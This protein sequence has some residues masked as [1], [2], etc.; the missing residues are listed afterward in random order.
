MNGNNKIAYVLIFALFFRLFMVFGLPLKTFDNTIK[1]YHYAAINL[2]EGRGYSHSDKPPYE[3][4]FYK[5][6]VYPFFL[7]AIYWVFGIHPNAVK[8]VQI[9]LDVF[10]CLILFLLL[11]HY[12]KP[13]I[14]Y[15]GLILSAFCPFTA[16]YT[17]SLSPESLIIFL[18]LGTLW[19]VSKA[20][21]VNRP[22][23]FLGAGLTSMLMAYS[24]QELFP[25]VTI[26]CGYLFIS[27]MK[28]YWEFKKIFIFVFGALLIMTP[29]FFRNY[30]L[31][32]KPMLLGDGSGL[33]LVLFAG[34]IEDKLNDDISGEKYL[35]AH[36][37]IKPFYEQW[38]K[39]VLKSDSSYEEKMK[40]DKYFLDLALDSIKRDPVGFVSMRLSRAPRVWLNIHPNEFAFLNSQQ[41]RM[42]H[43]ELKKISD[44]LKNN[45][46]GV[47]I[48][49]SK[50]LL[51]LINLVY[52][53]FALIGIWSVRKRAIL[54]SFVILPLIYAQVF[55]FF[56][57]IAEYYTIPYWG[58]I[59]FFSSIGCYRISR[60]FYDG[61]TQ[62]LNVVV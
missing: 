27:Q 17:N 42:F 49:L 18:M 30:M 54:L 13:E 35:N 14:A 26:F 32:G 40:S 7:A 34:S 53:I 52:I 38:Y 5:P 44:A 50:Y 15:C 25:L 41:L 29:W 31:T 11:K 24:R 46:K 57:H 10:G 59:L 22:V 51:F 36:P 12:F 9:F 2:I 37:E 47:I 8:V 39:T 21:I 60:I 16:V 45:F 61:F 20:T 62:S 43:P 1:R 23:F 28:K 33:G 55:F 6:P 19:M 3:P 58:C 56:F 48:L 4:S